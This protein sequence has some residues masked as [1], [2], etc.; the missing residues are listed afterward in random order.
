MNK[1][2]SVHHIFNTL[3][4]DTT[5]NSYFKGQTAEGNYVQADNEL[6]RIYP[7]YHDI[8]DGRDK[9]LIILKSSGKP[10]N[11]E[12]L[13]Y[14][15]E[16]FFRYGKNERAFQYLLE[17][18]S[19]ELERREYPEVSF[20]AIGAITGG[21]M[22]IHPRASQNLIETLPNLPKQVYWAEINNVPVFQNQISVK[23][24]GIKETIFTN[25]SGNEILWIASFPSLT[26]VLSLNG[27]KK[28]CERTY[29]N[30]Q[31][32]SFL[33]VKVKPGET[34]NVSVPF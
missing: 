9:E 33:I 32:I 17:Q 31:T 5:A 2:D 8:V 1:A 15:S 21:L 30:G 26:N 3:W 4:W 16:I 18:L 7:L 19:P 14:L 24:K 11:T 25:I 20:T 23:H 10:S 29:R 13:T 6:L 34:F 12:E 22:G 27:E 28:P